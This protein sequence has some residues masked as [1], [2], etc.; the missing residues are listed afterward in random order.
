MR[1]NSRTMP[2][3][4]VGLGTMGSVMARNV[5]E[6]GFPLC[7]FDVRPEPMAQ[8]TAL[9]AATAGSPREVAERSE[10]IEVAVGDTAQVEEVIVGPEG[11][12]AGVS[13]GAVIAVHS[14]IYPLALRPLAEE[15]EARGVHILDAQMSGAQRGATSQSL[16]FMVGGDADALE[17]CRPVLEASGK[18]IFHMGGLGMGAATKLAQQIVTTVNL[19]AATEGF[20]VAK[21]AGVDMDKFRAVLSLSTGQ[22]F[23]ADTLMGFPSPQGSRRPAAER[24]EDRPF[25]RGLRACL[26]LAADL[27]VSVP[28]AA[29]AQQQIPWSLSSGEEFV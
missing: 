22:S 6:A 18:H 27:D 28:G 12:L 17:R 24:A 11:L 2:V 23:V 4:F 25:F 16:I 9:G 1:A 14:T 20:R 21:K 3:G 15:A 10:V 5:L 8:L 26:A 19:L 7:V 13:P 29:L